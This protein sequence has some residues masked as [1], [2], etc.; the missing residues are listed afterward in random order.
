[1]KDSPLDKFFEIIKTYCKELCDVKIR[2]HTEDEHWYNDKHLFDWISG[3][4]VEV[5]LLKSRISELEED[6]EKAK[7]EIDETMSAHLEQEHCDD[8]TLSNDWADE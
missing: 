1:M 8:D 4:I 3:F 5:E 6:L 7:E 2:H